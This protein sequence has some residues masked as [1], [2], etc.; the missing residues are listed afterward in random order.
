MNVQLARARAA[1]RRG[2]VEKSPVVTRVVV[3]DRPVRSDEQDAEVQMLLDANARLA[4]DRDA[5]RAECARLEAH[6][7]LKVAS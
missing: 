4:K 6:L 3:K 1:S 5:W 2:F 7:T